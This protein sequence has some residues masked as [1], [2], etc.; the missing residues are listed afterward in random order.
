M[1][2]VHPEYEVYAIRYATKPR[3]ARHLFI[4]SD[5]HDSDSA[6]DYFIWLIKHPSRVVVVDTGFSADA[7]R[8]R[9][10]TF[11]YP[12]TE[13][14]AA[15]GVQASQVSDV[16]LTHLHYDH[17]GGFADFPSAAFHLQDDELAFATGRHMQHRF[18]SQAYEVEEVVEI[19]RRVYGGRVR[20]HDG[21]VELFPGISLHLVG[22]HTKGLQ[23]VRVQTRVGPVVLASDAVHLYA[24]RD[25]G[26]PFPIL[27]DVSAMFAGWDRALML[28]GDEAR[29]IPGHD[30][31]V[32]QRFP[33][34]E[35]AL[36][37]WVAR[38]DAPPLA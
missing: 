32:M 4:G 8:R 5:A 37:G 21:D 18:F 9:D 34:P 30:P 19:V 12:P 27:Q 14:L 15:L 10:R 35:P 22:G 20:F 25:R 17:V 7:G 29:V 28:A 2:L 11:L 1:T 36:Q 6:L 31:L 24:N 16:I 23:V 13:G 33:A 3:E 38:L 26:N